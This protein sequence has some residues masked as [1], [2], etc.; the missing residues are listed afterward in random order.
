FRD[1]AQSKYEANQVSQQDVLQAE[2]E[3]AKL[4]QARINLDQMRRVTAARINTLLHR[5]P[6]H[7][8]PAPPQHLTV[9]EE[10]PGVEELRQRAVEQRPDLAAT[11][12]RIAAE[13][14]SV[15]LACKEFYPDFEFMGRYDAFWTD[16]EQRPQVGMNVNVPLNQCRRQAAVRE[17]MFRLS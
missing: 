7:P 5:L 14:N 13:Q 17:A 9:D 8:L 4:A 15:A 1:A 11:A 10:L 2:V 16:H 3:L 12:A 6:D